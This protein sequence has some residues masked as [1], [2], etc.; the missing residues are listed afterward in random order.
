[1][2]H[3]LPEWRRMSHFSPDCTLR[4]RCW[5][6][7]S[8]WR[9]HKKLKWEEWI[10]HVKE[11]RKGAHKGIPVSWQ[12]FR[13]WLSALLKAQLSSCLLNSICYLCALIINPPFC[14]SWLHWVSVI[15]TY[16]K[17][18]RLWVSVPPL[19]N[20]GTVLEQL[21]SVKPYTVCRQLETKQCRLHN[22]LESSP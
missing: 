9:L 11:Q 20:E 2:N 3:F 19:E 6:T 12:H 10:R 1:M 16:S 21:P 4:N 8:W 13:S 22:W 7:F 17:P 15:Y 18:S 14:L 5:P